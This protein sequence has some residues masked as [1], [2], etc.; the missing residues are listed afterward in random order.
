MDNRDGGDKGF[1]TAAI[2][3]LLLGFIIS[4]ADDSKRLPAIINT[5]RSKGMEKF[6][7]GDFVSVGNDIGVIVFLEFEN[8]TPE[9]HLGVWYGEQTDEGKPKCRTV[10]ADYCKPIQDVA[11]YH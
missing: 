9:D 2:W 7:K 10:P 3:D 6:L 4:T 11:I 5:R 1:G 8:Q